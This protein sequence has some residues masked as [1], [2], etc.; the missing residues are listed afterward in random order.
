MTPFDEFDVEKY[1]SFEKSTTFGMAKKWSWGQNFWISKNDPRRPHL[2]SLKWKNN[3]HYNIRLNT[4]YLISDMQL[5][6]TFKK[7]NWFDG[8]RSIA[9]LAQYVI[10]RIAEDLSV[11][12]LK[13]TKSEDPK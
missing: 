12:N 1:F 2:M 10:L 13:W 9:E 7:S 4:E 3:F 8:P 11:L 5:R 6:L